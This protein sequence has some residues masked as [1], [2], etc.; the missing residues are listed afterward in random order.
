MSAAAAVPLFCCQ[1]ASDAGTV[2]YRGYGIPSSVTPNIPPRVN[3]RRR[4]NPGF[5][6]LLTL[7]CKNLG[8]RGRIPEFRGSPQVHGKI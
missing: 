8:Y 1:L 7:A 6:V 5:R 2:A 4:N 3:S